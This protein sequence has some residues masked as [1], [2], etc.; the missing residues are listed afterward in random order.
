MAGGR[1]GK[2]LMR[3]WML[4]VA[5]DANRFTSVRSLLGRRRP[6]RNSKVFAYKVEPAGELRES[7]PAPVA[8]S[9]LIV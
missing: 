5:A 7:K 2:F 8:V 1:F 9:S 4:R 3:F 6:G